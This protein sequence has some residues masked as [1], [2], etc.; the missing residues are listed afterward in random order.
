MIAIA[1]FNLQSIAIENFV[2]Q[3]IGIANLNSQLIG[4]AKIV[5]QSIH[6][7]IQSLKWIMQSPKW[8]TIFLQSVSIAFPIEISI[9]FDYISNPYCNPI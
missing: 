9:H 5:L 3:S 2:L 4:I 1:N 8:I 6:K 7:E